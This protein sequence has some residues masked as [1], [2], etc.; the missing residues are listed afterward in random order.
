MW[1]LYYDDRTTCSSNDGSWTDAP[2]W[3]VMAVAYV[4]DV[5]GYER[6]TGDFYI[7]PESQPWACDAWGLMDYLLVR[8]ALA[9]NQPLTDLTADELVA[10]GVKFGRS[11]RHDEWREIISW[12]N[13]DPELPHKS[14]RYAHERP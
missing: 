9:P 12:I 5:V 2:P 4:D 1:K 10:A 3:G 8:G 14:G 13:S 11:V 6:D 7:M